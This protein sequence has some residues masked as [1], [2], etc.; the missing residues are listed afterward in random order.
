MSRIELTSGKLIAKNTIS[1]L[2]AQMIPMVV[3]FFALP[4]LVKSLQM[5]RFGLL[6][7]IWTIIGYFA[8]TDL[9]LGRVVIKFVAERVRTSNESEIPEILWTA[10]FIMFSVGLL[11]SLILAGISP[12]L[13]N[14]VYDIPAYLHDESLRSF[15]ALSLTVIPVILTAAMRGIL[16]AQQ[17]FSWINILHAGVGTMT[18]FG[19]FLVVRWYPHIDVVVYFL[20]GVRWLSLFIHFYLSYHFTP[21]FFSRFQLNRK[22]VPRLFRF[23]AWLTASNL[24]ISVKVYVDRLIVGMLVPLSEVAVY[25]TPVEV[26]SRVLFIPGALVRVLFPAFASIAID[27]KK[28]IMVLF[29]RGTKIIGLTMFMMTFTMIAFA[30]EGLH[31]WLGPS[32]RGKGALNLQILALGVFINSFGWIPITFLHSRE[33]ADLTAKFHIVETLLYIG[34]IYLFV[35]QL[36]TVGASISRSMIELL[37]LTGLLYLIHRVNPE[38]KINHKQLFQIIGLMLVLSFPFIFEIGIVVKISIYLGSMIL[39]LLFY[40]GVVFT[41]EDRIYLLNLIQKFTSTKSK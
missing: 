9:G 14:R 28:S 12:I 2:I 34:M 21:H 11:F 23:G 40:W 39:F 33:R 16:E 6:T 19:P 29:D 4:P 37:D 18:Y 26:L 20:S 25:T 30:P 31:I 3:G 41:F 38:V 13:I 7:L 8:F 17:N 24:I 5:E 1:S 35:S 22:I 32:F 36:S 27:D 10:L 15:Y